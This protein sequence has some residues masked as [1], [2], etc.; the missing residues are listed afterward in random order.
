[1]TSVEYVRDFKPMNINEI[2]AKPMVGMWT[3]S[4]ALYGKGTSGT[5]S[6][7]TS[8]T[9]TETDATDETIAKAVN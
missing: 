4:G 6:F 5:F 1:M 7:S 2:D 3:D 9:S 8:V